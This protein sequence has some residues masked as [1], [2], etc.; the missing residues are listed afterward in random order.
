MVNNNLKMFICSK[1]AKS[2]SF[3]LFILACTPSFAQQRSGKPAA[4]DTFK[5]ADRYIAKKK[6][7][8]A[9]GLYKAYHQS[10]PR[11]INSLWKL[12]Q[13]KFWLNNFRQ[14]DTLYRSALKLGPANDYLRLNYIHSLLDMGKMGQAEMMLTDMELAGKD[15]SDMSLLRAKLN[16]YQG[17]YKQAAAYIRKSLNA[18]NN[19][20]D[21]HELDDQIEIARAPLVSLNSGYLSDN[22]PLAAI[23]STVRVENYFSKYSDLYLTCDEYHF[24]Q[25]VVSD[26]PWVRVGDILYFPNAGLHINFSAGI[27]KYPVM[28]EYGVSGSLSL[29]EKISRH[30]DIDV[31]ADHTP[32]LDTKTSIDTDIHVTKVAAMLN[33]HLR[34]WSA[35]AAVMNS[36]YPDN[37]NVYGAYGWVLA[38]ITSFSHGQ[39][40]AGYSISY[41]NSNFSSYTS[42]RTLS[43]VL[44]NYTTNPNVTGV[45]NPYFTPNELFV[46]SGLVA[47][48]LIPSKKVSI[49]LGGDV[50]YGSI[51]APYLFLDKD[52]NGNVF[53]DRGFAM[54]SFVSADAKATINYHINNSW[55]LSA[56]YVYTNTYFFTSN[57]IS[58]GIQKSFLHNKKRESESI[59]S[60]FGKLIYNIESDLQALYKD[61]NEQDVKTSVS[62]IRRELMKL[63]DAQKSKMNLAESAQGNDEASTLQD[64]YDNLNGMIDEL[65]A[66]DLNDYNSS[67]KSKKEWLVDKLYEL[68]SITYN[69]NLD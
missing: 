19:N 22:Q 28:N 62:N 6:F 33:W 4:I 35:Q 23:I 1:I 24:M 29:N 53:I 31:T 45:Y 41:S 25:D 26:A 52:V 11:D 47:L 14:S 58:L 17:D 38:P 30:F 5:Q 63:R 37:N 32:Y 40:L 57:F 61:H 50:G 2:V 67:G 21:A 8:K 7:R 69:G 12:A 9:A 3:L 60:T 49:N 44:A 55:L 59:G 10:H 68:T 42:D 51:N 15:Y 34:N 13:T 27:F 36:I 39:L 43:E 54:Q 20:T 16:Y 65:D 64:R 56:K 18:E 66:V 46:N 48:N